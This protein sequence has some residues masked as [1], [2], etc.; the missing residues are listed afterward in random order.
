MAEGDNKQDLYVAMRGHGNVGKSLTS[1][2]QAYR[3]YLDPS[4]SN[5]PCPSYVRELLGDY[6]IPSMYFKIPD[7]DPHISP[8]NFDKQPYNV[9]HVIDAIHRDLMGTLRNVQMTT[10]VPADVMN[11][12]MQKP[13]VA[14]LID[15]NNQR[16]ARL[17]SSKRKPNEMA[18]NDPAMTETHHL[19]VMT[20]VAHCFP[21][22]MPEVSFTLKDKNTGEED[23]ITV[24]N[25]LIHRDEPRHIQSSKMPTGIPL[26][27]IAWALGEASQGQILG[28]RASMFIQFLAGTQQGLTT[29][30][31]AMFK[32]IRSQVPDGKSL[33]DY[34]VNDGAQL[35]QVVHQEAKPLQVLQMM[36]QTSLQPH[37]A[38]GI[39][40]I[41][42]GAGV[43]ESDFSLK[44]DNA[45]RHT[46]CLM[47]ATAEGFRKFGNTIKT[48]RKDSQDTKKLFEAMNKPENISK[49]CQS[50]E[51]L[52]D[53]VSK[54]GSCDEVISLLK[55]KPNRQVLEKFSSRLQLL[56]KHCPDLAIGV[57]I[58]DQASCMV[59]PTL[60]TSLKVIE[61]DLVPD[62]LPTPTQ[63]KRLPNIDEFFQQQMDRRSGDGSH[64]NLP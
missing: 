1:L 20:M 52:A 8:V 33:S 28:S 54:C 18:I 40:S 56:A 11:E 53:D 60:L 4:V 23:T 14:Q 62:L 57:G 7:Q 19:A 26:A 3:H 27:S 48:Q 50:L 45:G 16:V 49:A 13:E 36:A 6:T 41:L 17:M 30:M 61:R 12:Q 39:R 15:E 43:K 59:L 35:A 38:R 51:K 34:L 46:A 32:A 24:A 9:A 31:E 55:R 63:T 10:T 58:E 29:S 22:I 2:V 5:T 25:M 64:W 37:E 47:H 42:S 21:Q 44:D